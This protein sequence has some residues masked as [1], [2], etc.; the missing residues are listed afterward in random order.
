MGL[1]RGLL[2]PFRGAAFVAKHGLWGYVAVPI[3]V[4]VLIA[5]VSGFAAYRL[6]TRW[7]PL[8]SNAWWQVGTAVLAVVLVV[9]VFLILYPLVSSPFIDLLTEKT[10]SIVTGSHPSAGLWMG[11]AQALLHGVAKSGL[12]L[13]ALGFTA[14]LSLFLGPAAVLGLVLGALFLGYDGFDYPLARR[15]VSFLGKWRYLFSNFAQTAGYCASASALYALPLAFIVAPP[16]VC[17][18]A[19]LAYLDQQ[20]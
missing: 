8:Q 19:T 15:R 20:R 12:Y 16:F 6:A 7:A 13:F 2:A 9:P 3:V 4:N 14:A 11:A 5:L 10:E 17:V 1:Y 18:G